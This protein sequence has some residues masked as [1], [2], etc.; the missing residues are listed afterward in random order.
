MV[1]FISAFISFHLPRTPN[2]LMGLGGLLMAAIMPLPAFAGATNDAGAYDVSPKSFCQAMQGQIS[3]LT[4]A[5]DSNWLIPAL[6]KDWHLTEYEQNNR[7]R[8]T[9]ITAKMANAETARVELQ[10]VAMKGVLAGLRLIE[11]HSAQIDQTEQTDQTG[12][13]FR[14]F[15][16]YS[17]GADCAVRQ[18]HH[19]SFAK[20][21]V[22]DLLTITTPGTEPYEIAL[23][24]APEFNQRLRRAATAEKQNIPIVGHIDSGIDYQRPDVQR[25]LL[26]DDNGRWLALDLWDDDDRPYDS[27]VSRSPFQPTPHGTY[28]IDIMM[29]YGMDFGF[30]PVRYPRPDMARMGDAIDWLAAHSASIVIMPLGSNT[31]DDWHSFNAAAQ[32]HPT[33]LFIIS[34][35][36]N[37]QDLDKN[38]IYP[39]VN[40]LTNA[41]TVTSVNADASIAM[42]SNYSDSWVD[43]GVAAENINANGVGNFPQ[44]VSGS[45]FAVP[46]LASFA[47]CT[48]L[49]N[50]NLAHQN[51]AQR[52]A[53]LI[54]ALVSDPGTAKTSRA[55]VVN[56]GYGHFLS[57][58]IITNTCR[59]VAAP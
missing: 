5:G 49:K 53:S 32:R 59:A 33:I 21:G 13:V 57:D 11:A 44:T 50:P 1:V 9:I 35:G 58:A 22:A 3:S 18:T 43:V 34:A 45:S 23:N 6:P 31:P 55:S 47:L 14:P 25:H 27:D 51:G 48:A 19:L 46:K 39:G 7:P 29:K 37:G 2:C 26:A 56:R 40:D 16:Q 52:A 41:L 15:R 10:I 8:A 30:L 12:Q 38:P 24:P 4:D 54:A 17:L 42:G 28:L 36:N 20:N